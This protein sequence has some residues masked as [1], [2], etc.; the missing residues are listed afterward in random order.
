MNEANRA[1]S[2]DSQQRRSRLQDSGLFFLSGPS[3]STRTET[4]EA[5]RVGLFATGPA[6]IRNVDD[7][8]VSLVVA[9]V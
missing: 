7:P 8:R 1:K 9:P 2:N 6:P 5:R 4:R 3:W